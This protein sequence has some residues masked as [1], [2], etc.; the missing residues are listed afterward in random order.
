[1]ATTCHVAHIHP[2]L[3][4]ELY[5]KLLLENCRVF[6]FAFFFYENKQVKVEKTV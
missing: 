1:M 6:F 4:N 3:K 2:P 5:I